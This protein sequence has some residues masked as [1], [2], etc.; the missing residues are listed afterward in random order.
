M[1]LREWREKNSI[2]L[3]EL[4]EAVEVSLGH[5][6]H[7]ELGKK[8]W[9]VELAKRVEAFTRGK[10]SATSLLGLSENPRRGRGVREEAAEFEAGSPLTVHVSVA[11]DQAGLLKRQGVDIEAVARAGAQKALKEAEARA[12]ADSNREAIDAYNA[13]I[14]KHGTLAEQLGLI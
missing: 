2:T 1:E 5:L 8:A 7:L 13:W 9:S 12:W 3:A 14:D 4:S 10:I 11:A 6:S